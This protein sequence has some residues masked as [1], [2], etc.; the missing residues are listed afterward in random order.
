MRPMPWKWITAACSLSYALSSHASVQDA[1]AGQYIADGDRLLCNLENGG[2]QF[3]I[4]KR[5][6]KIRLG[7]RLDMSQYKTTHASIAGWSLR[8]EQGQKMIVPVEPITIKDQFVLI[9]GKGFA[10]GVQEQTLRPSASGLMKASI[11]VKKC[12]SEDCDRGAKL[13][14]SEVEYTVDVCTVQLPPE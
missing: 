8:D 5:G 3:F 12:P 4:A 7:Y 9:N 11:S 1:W 14:T 10:E 6:T 13:N 2:E